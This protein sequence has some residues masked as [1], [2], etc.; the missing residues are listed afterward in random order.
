VEK[1][2]YKMSSYIKKFN[3][4]EMEE[5]E[6]LALAT[7]RERLLE[8]MLQE[9]QQCKKNNSNQHYVLYG[10]RGIGKSFFTRLLKI[11]HDN[12]EIFMDSIFLQ[13]PEEQDNINFTADLLDVISTLLEGGKLVDVNPKWEITT[14]QYQASVKRLKAAIAKVAKEKNIKHIFVTQE[15]LQVFIPKLSNTESGRLREFLSDFN[16]ITLIGSSLRPD[17]DNDYAKKL[18][19]VFKKIDIE[20]WSEESFLK[21]YERK[22]LRSI[23]KTE[24]LEQLKKS[25]NKI[26]AI[27][28]F[29]GGSPRLAVILSNLILDKNILDTTEL[30]DGIIDD[31][32][33]YYQ[34]ITNDIPNKSKMLF[35]ML[36]RK[37]ENMTQSELAQ[38]FD[39]PLEQSTIARSF[40][41]LLDNYYVVSTKQAKGHTKHIFVRDRLYVLYYQKRQV[42]ADVP[43]SFIGIFVDFLTEFYSQKEIKSEISSMDTNHRYSKEILYHFA[44]KEKLAID[45]TLDTVDLKNALLINYELKTII[46]LKNLVAEAM[47]NY[48]KNEIDK[49]IKKFKKSIALK[50]DDIQRD[51]LLGIIYLNIKKYDKVIIILTNYI[52]IDPNSDEANACLGCAYMGI[53]TYKEAFEYFQKAIDINPNKADFYSLLGEALS[54]MGQFNKAEENFLKAIE[55]N[56]NVADY[57]SSLGEALY[58]IGQYNKAIES[59]LKAKALNPNLDEYFTSIAK[60][61]C[62][63]NQID[64][65]LEFFH[66]GLELNPNNIETLTNL[67]IAYMLNNNFE[68]AIETFQNALIIDP[69]FHHLNLAY[70]N[71]IIITK[72]WQ[73]LEDELNKTDKTINSVAILGE[74]LYKTLVP[75]EVVEKFFLFNKT[76][77]ICKEIEKFNLYQFINTLCLG[78]YA[79][80]DFSFIE[81]VI[82]ELEADAKNNQLMNHIIAVFRYLIAPE[83]QDINKLHPDART[84]VE[85]ILAENEKEK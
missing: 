83:K 7:G 55:I 34:D 40:S 72:S 37:G 71:A 43:Y 50:P 73:L 6:V 14:M 33:S 8:T 21:Y 11:H 56:P 59:Y 16:E 38:S 78:L 77:S 85:S 61:Y 1:E 35:D 52:K 44:K 54:C 48:E 24:N 66:K 19:Q 23:H 9:M 28:K 70:F 69:N 36:I 80:H 58:R 84:I 22:S 13:L 41:W 2:K 64:K 26:K 76:Y 29:T 18:F 17:L 49:C 10:P 15:N 68:D 57:H 79:A 5:E 32:T 75:V 3:P 39:P 47:V 63:I 67:G 42:Y 82:D 4:L 65:A 31:L 62:K 30:L 51:L 45:Q 25:K 20:P 46:E 53:H 74:A 81:N 60:S 27:V 12:S